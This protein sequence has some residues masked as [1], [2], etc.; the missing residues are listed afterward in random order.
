MPTTAGPFT[1]KQYQY[2][3]ALPMLLR[4]SVKNGSTALYPHLAQLP[5]SITIARDYA[6]HWQSQNIQNVGLDKIRDLKSGVLI[7]SNIDLQTL[8]SLGAEYDVER[9][10]FLHHV[11]RKQRH[12]RGLGTAL[13]Q[14]CRRCWHVDCERGGRYRA[15]DFSLRQ[16]GDD[17]ILRPAMLQSDDD[18]HIRLSITRLTD[19]KCMCKFRVGLD[20][21]SQGSRP[22][23]R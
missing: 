5:I 21:S 1:I 14:P 18:G 17:N 23:P 12:L 15:V 2:A 4:E 16:D 20:R 8:V 3:E 9:S 6:G 10:F 22:R 7:I 19:E 11:L 13:Q